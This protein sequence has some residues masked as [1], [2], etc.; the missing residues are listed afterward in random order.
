MFAVRRGCNY[1]LKI[2]PIYSP[3]YD[4][5]LIWAL[6]VSVCYFLLSKRYLS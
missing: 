1:N 4:T 6:F 5:F 2:S 3:M